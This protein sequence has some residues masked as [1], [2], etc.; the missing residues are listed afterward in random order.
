MYDF[1]VVGAGAYGSATAYHLA[2]AGASVVVIDAGKLASGASGGFGKRGIRTN[3][4]D[5][6]ELDLIREAHAAWPGLSDELDADTGFERIGGV[7]LVEDQPSGLS[8]GVA[9]ARRRAT[10]QGD[11]GIPTE[12]WDQAA[13]RAKL[14]A[15]A[16]TIGGAL[17][18]PLDGVSSQEA[19][20]IAYARA[21]QRHGAV[22]I[23]DTGIEKLVKA[24]SSDVAGVLTAKGDRIDARRA[25][26]LTNNAG[27]GE[28]IHTVC[29]YQLP[30][31]KVLPQ[32]LLVR[33]E[34]T[35]SIPYLT[36]HQ[37]KVIS[38]KL[39]KDS[40]IMLSGGWLGAW[41][42]G[43]ARGGRPVQ[44][45]IEGNIELLRQTFPGLG[46]LTLLSADASRIESSSLDQVPFIDLIPGTRNAFVAT[47]WSG[48]GW[49][50]LPVVAR[51]LAAWLLT[52]KK[53]IEFDPFTISRLRR[54]SDMADIPA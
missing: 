42:G 45:R 11:F 5:P 4:R 41:D 26:L 43:G 49:A 37:S 15:V 33:S 40:T 3:M 52:G 36:N 7:C 27:A 2:K 23:E 24:G 12:Y 14:P 8:A 13:L 16:E 20:T 47:G 9:S 10:V 25:V 18:S 50:L 32:V 48:H 6:R 29:N 1:T 34:Y 44:S 53:P 17:Y 28:L 22:F 46:E 54:R 35:P 30:I 19:T 31:W 39:M 21:A 38:L 51:Q